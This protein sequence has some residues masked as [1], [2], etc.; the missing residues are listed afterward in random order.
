MRVQVTT[1]TTTMDWSSDDHAVVSDDHAMVSDGSGV[2]CVTGSTAIDALRLALGSTLGAFIALAVVIAFV[3]L[4]KCQ[5]RRR[6]QRVRRRRR[7]YSDKSQPLTDSDNI[8][9]FDYYDDN[10]DDYGSVC[11]DNG[12]N[13][14]VAAAVATESS[15]IRFPLPP[16]CDKTRLIFTDEF[17][18][19][20][21][22]DVAGREWSVSQ[23]YDG[24]SVAETEMDSTQLGRIA[25]GTRTNSVFDSSMAC[26]AVFVSGVVSDDNEERPVVGQGFRVAP[27]SMPATRCFN[28]DVVDEPFM[29]TV[30]PNHEV[31]RL[32]SEKQLGGIVD[33]MPTDCRDT[34]GLLST[35]GVQRTTGGLKP[36]HYSSLW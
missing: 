32:M 33:V 20:D 6:V 14:E 19:A 27:S 34:T 3:L 10:E 12:Q 11:I 36:N 35:P 25:A 7:R 26:P 1:T 18:V 22:I 8:S 30:G 31:L 24:E 13:D 17:V 9:F 21:D 2:S 23:F 29:A 15:A 4:A 5:H 28:Y 16:Q